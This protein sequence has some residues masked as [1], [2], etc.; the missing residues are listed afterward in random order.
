M[1]EGIAEAKGWEDLK[2]LL[3]QRKMVLAPFCNGIDCE[4]EIKEETTA[5][6]RCIP[7]GQKK[8]LP[9]C[10]KCGKPAEVNVLFAK[11]Y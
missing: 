7:F 11:A 8:T 6:A 2:K 5:T 10:V 3:E 1:D 4:K 9:K